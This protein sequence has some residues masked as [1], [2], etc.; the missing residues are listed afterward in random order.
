M[1]MKQIYIFSSRVFCLL[2]VAAHYLVRRHGESE[3]IHL[4]LVLDDMI[5]LVVEIAIDLR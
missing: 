3:E 2:A 1:E 4:I 5:S